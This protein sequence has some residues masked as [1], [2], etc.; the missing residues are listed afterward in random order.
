MAAQIRHFILG[1]A[2]YYDPATAQFLSRD[3]ISQR[4]RSPYGYVYG[5]PL[6]ARD[7]SG[8]DCDWTSPWDCVEEHAGD[9]STVTGILATVTAPIGP[10]SLGFGATSIV[11]GGYQTYKDV[12]DN[13]VGASILDVLGMV[14][15][16]GAEYKGLRGLSGEMRADRVLEQIDWYSHFGGNPAIVIDG[17]TVWSDIA[18]RFGQHY[19]WAGALGLFSNGSG[20]M[21]S[22]YSYICI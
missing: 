3:P 1:H 11:T 16:V 6:N 9:I 15:G 10:L 19:G 7:P 4:T 5:N 17:Y 21:G 14:P 13:N 12:R 2:R 20:I 22:A 8:L 18:G